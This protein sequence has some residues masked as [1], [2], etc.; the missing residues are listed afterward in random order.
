MTQTLI[1]TGSPSATSRSRRFAEI[2]TD[3]LSKLGLDSSLLDLRTLPPEP[4]LHADPEAPEIAQA[5]GRLAAASGVV[6][7]TPVYKAAYSGL[8]K[9]FLDIVPQFGLREKVVAPFAV[10]GT[11]AHVLSIDYGLRPVLSSLD[12]QH[13]VAGLFVL[14]KQIAVAPDGRVQLEPEL[15]P[16]VDA[17]LA[18][19]AAG[20][21]R[22]RTPLRE[23]A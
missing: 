3:R 11:L 13:V 18:S 6:F 23:S 21:R 12:P 15:S 2:L 14:D 8:L 17:A 20:L 7:V 5:L 19:Y 1:V 9:T 4:L 10:G 16:K 22:A